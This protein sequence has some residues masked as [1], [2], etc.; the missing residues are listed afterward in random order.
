MSLSAP[1][2]YE[3]SSKGYHFSENQ[4]KSDSGVNPAIRTGL[5]SNWCRLLVGINPLGIKP[6]G[7]YVAYAPIRNLPSTFLYCR[8][9]TV[10]EW[11]SGHVFILPP[12]TKLGSLIYHR[13][14]PPQGMSKNKNTTYFLEAEFIGAAHPR[15]CA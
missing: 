3:R 11:N 9:M 8:P 7:L 10:L 4:N 15:R 5:H 13:S 12:F 1:P 2:G 6:L 14:Q